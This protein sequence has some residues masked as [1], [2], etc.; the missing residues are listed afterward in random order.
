MTDERVGREL[1]ILTGNLVIKRGEGWTGDFVCAVKAQE[2]F[3][4]LKAEH[5]KEIKSKV[6]EELERMRAKIIERGEYKPTDFQ[7]IDS[8]LSE[9]DAVSELAKAREVIEFIKTKEPHAFMECTEQ[10]EIYSRVNAYLD[11]N[12]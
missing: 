10:E 9:F 12:K 4:A 2:A 8:L 6:R 3:D 5:T 11:G 1:E 7:L